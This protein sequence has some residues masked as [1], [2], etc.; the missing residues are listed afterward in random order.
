MGRSRGDSLV[1]DIA[2]ESTITKNNTAVNDILDD[3]YLINRLEKLSIALGKSSKKNFEEETSTVDE[4]GRQESVESSTT[5]TDVPYVVYQDYLDELNDNLND[6][7]EILNKSKL[8]TQDFNES[9][10][11]YDKISENSIK[12]INETDTLFQKHKQLTNK[13][14]LIPY[15]LN[16]FDSLDVVMRRL[17]HANSPA[18]VKKD[19]FKKLLN[20]ID[21]SLIFL[22]ENSN[23]LDA[24]SYRIKFKQCLIRAMMLISHFNNNTIKNIFNE[25]TQKDTMLKNISTRDA[26]IYNKFSNVS[27]LYLDQV[28][29]II[30][31]CYN[32]KFEKYHEELKSILND[33]FYTYFLYRN[34]LIMPGVW[35][36][37]DEIL[38]SE[39]KIG[40]VE[41][42]QSMKTYFQQLCVNEYQLFCK[43][44]PVDS[45]NVAVKNA[46]NKWF[47]KLC[48]PLYDTTTSIILI[49]D[50]ISNLCEVITLFKP[51]YE[52]EENSDEYMRQFNEIYYNKIFEPITQKLQ[53]QLHKAIRLFVND[54]LVKYQP[55]L[56]D[57][58]VTSVDW[59]NIDLENDLILNDYL[60]NLSSRLVQDGFDHTLCS[61]DMLLTRYY[62]PLIKS[63]ALLTK[64]FDIFINPNLFVDLSH[65][66]ITN[67]L[68][69]LR[70]AYGLYKDD[71][72]TLDIKLSTLSN[73]LLL[74]DEVQRFNIPS[75]NFDETKS[76]FSFSAVGSII[77][78]LK[79]S[80]ANI[81]SL[82]KNLTQV[83]V[84]NNSSTSLA[85][86][87]GN[88][89][90]TE[91]FDSR[92]E[93]IH[94]LRSIIK[95]FTESASNQILTKDILLLETDKMADIVDK[96]DKLKKNIQE[97]LPI[98]DSKIISQIH[99]IEI[100]N[101]LLHAIKDHIM[102][103]YKN[104]YNELWSINS[105]SNE[106][107]NELNDTS[108]PNFFEELFDSVITDINISQVEKMTNK[109]NKNNS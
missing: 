42:I 35:L 97:T 27:E 92:M 26:L 63:M 105:E 3:T 66:V 20:T 96:N 62:T 51:F 84:R 90:K 23:L 2:S 13:S 57:L 9:L 72:N 21:E 39:K 82:A 37:L 87:P 29:E 76:T 38:A 101:H 12:F 65:Y 31:R 99:D 59:K 102:S 30:D 32:K 104:V 79:N 98:I 55:T 18:I 16:H 6:Y 64:V 49:Q 67:C 45:S 81:F 11:K 77:N 60:L 10:R 50:N 108:T 4:G 89:H 94:E 85:S 58:M 103:Q 43:F 15:Y 1:H 41:F 56:N 28:C 71:S 33:C 5:N 17:N 91:D 53:D 107:A 93:L 109:D 52:F 25:I 95:E 19:S 22:S 61:N 83:R 80:N 24:E 8:L 40:F 69:S 46:I 86:V 54:T 48:E 78:T 70:K 75:G 100:S 44:F 34:R 47:L 14:K 106:V 7:K 68:S 73:L 74:R 88:N 36:Q